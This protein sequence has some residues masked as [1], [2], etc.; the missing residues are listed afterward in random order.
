[1]TDTMFVALCSLLG[2]AVGSFSGMRLM[3]YR[4]QQLE[5]KVEKHNNFAERMP[6]VEK[7]IKQIYHE[8]DE[9]KHGGN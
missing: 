5:K 7:D 9:L 1:M 3:I 8:I 6:I 2:T 4:I